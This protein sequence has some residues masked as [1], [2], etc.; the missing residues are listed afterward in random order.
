MSATVS[1]PLN[2]PGSSPGNSPLSASVSSKD[3]IRSPQPAAKGPIATAMALGGSGAVAAGPA[4]LLIPA[5]SVGAPLAVPA[6][7]YDQ[8]PSR[9]GVWMQ[10]TCGWFLILPFCGLLAFL[11]RF[12]GR[13]RI[14]NQRE[15]RALYRELAKDKRPL[16]ICLN[17]LTFIDSALAIWAFG[18]NFWYQFHYAKFS[19]NLPAGDFFKKKLSH[20][21]VAYLAK[22]LFIHRDG[23]KRHKSAVLDLCMRLLRQG[24]VV[25]IF[26]EGKRS[27]TG[28]FEL[29]RL[30]YGVGKVCMELRD[31]RVLCAYIRGDR[32]ETFSNYPAKGSRFRIATQLITPATALEGRDGCADLTL[33]IARTIKGLEDQYFAARAQAG[34][35]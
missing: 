35:R 22:C 28:R 4:T 5:E 15:L 30:T 32:Q 24:E 1:S 31:C 8:V 13:Y 17:H 19:W 20:R 29:E 12:V 2:S 33:Q 26:P 10:R 34:N 27:R 6:A 18:S 11:F 23:T 9:L 25:T 7:E 21:T 16:L 3:V 14:E